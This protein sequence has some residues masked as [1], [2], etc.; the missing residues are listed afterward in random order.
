MKKLVLLTAFIFAAAFCN[1]KP[2]G[3]IDVT[4]KIYVDLLVIKEKYSANQDSL[5]IYKNQVFEKHNTAQDQYEKDLEL[6]GEDNENW[7]KFFKLSEAYIDTLRKSAV[8]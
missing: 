7:D 6:L 2:S 3:H 1:E 5:E 8:N 4:A